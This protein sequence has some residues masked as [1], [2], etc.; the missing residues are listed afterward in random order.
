[1]SM[2]RRM[3]C[4]VAVMMICTVQALAA[5]NHPA[6]TGD[7]NTPSPTVRI[8]LKRL[9]LT[10]RA[11]LTLDGVY[12]AK[13]STGTEIGFPR[14]SS[15]VIQLRNERLYLYYG[16]AAIDMGSSVTL[17]RMDAGSPDQDGI[18]FASGGNLYPGDL[19]LTISGSVLFP[20]LKVGL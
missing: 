1:M 19:T 16:G 13:A 7:M 12:M 9:N 18:R 4:I 14:G 11:D 20:I 2:L 6:V 15:T 5:T 3:L 17:T 10:D 8:Y